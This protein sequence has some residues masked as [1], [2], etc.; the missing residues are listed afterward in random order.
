ML[1]M[2]KQVSLPKI[3]SILQ[4]MKIGQNLI[5]TLLAQSPSI[6]YDSRQYIQNC[7]NECSEWKPEKHFARSMKRKE[8]I[9]EQLLAL[10]SFSQ[11]SWF[12]FL[13][14]KIN[15]KTLQ[16]FD[17]S[18]ARSSK[19]FTLCQAFQ[20]SIVTG[21]KT[22]LFFCVLICWLGVQSIIL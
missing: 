16:G 14:I 1:S 17:K 8:K 18:E 21:E 22:C 15:L 9:R 19:L 3:S 10:F 11:E 6:I 5:Y 13:R 2:S 12:F 7:L 20:V 4:K